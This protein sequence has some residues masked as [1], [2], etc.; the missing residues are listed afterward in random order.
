MVFDGF[1]QLL[2]RVQTLVE[3]ALQRIALAAPRGLELIERG[4]KGL[5]DGFAL[6]GA[7]GLISFRFD[8]LDHTA[9]PEQAVE[10]GR[11]RLN[12]A[13]QHGE[14]G[15]ERIENRL[16]DPDDRLRTLARHGQIG[17]AGAAHEA[18]GNRGAALRFKRVHAGRHAHPDIE[19]APVDRFQ[20]PGPARARP[21]TVGTGEPGHARKTHLNCL[22]DKC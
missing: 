3:N 15:D 22:L 8:D 18:G 10:R 11:R 13:F 19:A 20:L 7:G 4:Q 1:R 17:V 16:V 9:H 14:R 12:P 5:E 21:R 6:R 2:D